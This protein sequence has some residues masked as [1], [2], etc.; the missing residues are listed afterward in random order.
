LSCLA[1]IKSGFLQ[2]LQ[3]IGGHQ[4]IVLPSVDSTN[5]YATKLLR[6]TNV[7]SGTVILSH[8]QT[9]GKGQRGQAWESESGQNLTFSLVLNNLQIDSHSQFF[10]NKAIGIA[11]RHFVYNLTNTPTFIK[12]PNDILVE[13]KKI[14]GILIENSW[15]QH[16]IQHSIIGIGLNI[17]QIHF[18]NPQAISTA[19]I[20]D[21]ELDLFR[22]LHT[23]LESLDLWINK[24]RLQSFQEIESEY[25]SHLFGLHT[26]KKFLARGKSLDGK[27]L[28]VTDNGLL[29]IESD[30]QRQ[31]FDVKEIKF[32]Y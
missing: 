18:K 5:N 27:V 30:G 14:A 19:V 21:Q 23:L 4:V 3:V 8:S 31:K 29:L 17:N 2:N 15:Q 26:T 22:A 10:L 28:G 24:V 16:A 7:A 6:S 11:L 12:W 20:L 32:I 1:P 25:H 13:N 9:Q